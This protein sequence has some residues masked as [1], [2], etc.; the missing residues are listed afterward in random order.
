MSNNVSIARM[1]SDT[2]DDDNSFRKIFLVERRQIVSA[3]KTEQWSL[4]TS[5]SKHNTN[6]VVKMTQIEHN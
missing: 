2:Y 3:D 5:V 4:H 1:L 6:G